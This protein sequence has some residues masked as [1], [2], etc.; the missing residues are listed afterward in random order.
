[1]SFSLTDSRTTLET[2]LRRAT[3]SPVPRVWLAA[4]LVGLLAG[5]AAIGFRLAIG[6]VQF[7][8]LGDGT[9]NLFRI[10]ADTPAWVIVAGPTLAGLI[11]GLWLTYIQPNQRPEAIADVIEARAI[12]AGRMPVWR[13][14]GA[15]IVSIISLGGGASSGR[16]G[17][18]VHLGAT[19]GSYLGVR[20]GFS[21]THLRTL[22]AAGAASAVAASFNAPIAGV[23]FALE[24]VL[25]HYALRASG[26]IVIASVIGALLVRF[27]MGS[28]PTFVLPEYM[29][30]SLADFPAFAVLGVISA[31]I[32]VVFMQVAMKT[33]D[34]ARKVTIPLWLRPVIGGLLLGLIGLAFPEVLG[35]GY[36]AT[37]AAL[38]GEFSLTLLLSLVAMKIIATAITIA[39]RFG[40]GVFSPSLYLGAMAGGAFG[41]ILSYTVP[42]IAFSSH[43]V[44]ALVGM[45]AV[46]GA[47]LGAPLST[48]L[49]AFELT[50]GY[51]MTVALM[52]AISIATAL[53]QGFLGKS[54]FQWQLERR[55][56]NLYGGPRWQILQT[57]LVQDFMRRITEDPNTPLQTLD[58]D[59]ERLFTG[60]SLEKTLALFE[61]TQFETLPVVQPSEE[62][63]IVG[64]VSHTDALRAYNEALVEASREEHS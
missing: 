39:S 5:Y 31:I 41:L 52:V 61:A 62:V 14:L 6:G 2:T 47:V 11:V 43:G 1:M 16:E 26:P 40:G 64:T 50:G 8:W 56:L 48:L 9:E 45:G 30:A 49:I 37:D 54:F 21:P 20:F 3:T 19:L 7:L 57:V 33:D 23:I 29:I 17:P 10:L 15:A 59:D 18:A 38:Q 44:Y 22:L 13:G 42:D 63:E 27:H 34:L 12:G 51:E 46:A 28:S 53:T 58:E 25:G 32:A 55:G 35:V 24:V 36:A 4:I 60:D